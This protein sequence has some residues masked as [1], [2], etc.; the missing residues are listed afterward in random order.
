MHLWEDS[1]PHS[2]LRLEMLENASLGVNWV[3]VLVCAWKRL[4]MHLW[5]PSGPHSGLHLES[6]ENV[7]LVAF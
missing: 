5:K 6:F 2:G 7:Y 1:G 4:K 3:D